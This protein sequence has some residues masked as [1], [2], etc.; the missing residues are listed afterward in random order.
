MVVGKLATLGFFVRRAHGGAVITGVGI[1]GD[2]FGVGHAGLVVDFLVMPLALARWGYRRNDRARVVR[3]SIDDDL[4]F[5]RVAFL[6]ARVITPLR[7]AAVRPADALL[8]SVKKRVATS[9]GLALI[10]R[11]GMRNT[12]A[13][14]GRI[15]AMFRHTLLASRSNR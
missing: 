4:I 14:T 6:L 15:R 12:C 5:K 10:R 11:S 13:S 1:A 2:A 7:Y 9:S 8:G 3:T